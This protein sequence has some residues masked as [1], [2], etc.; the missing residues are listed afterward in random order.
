MAGPHIRWAAGRV[1]PALARYFT[2]VPQSSAAVRA[3]HGCSSGLRFFV[4]LVFSLEGFIGGPPIEGAG[5]GAKSPARALQRPGAAAVGED[6]EVADAVQPGGQD[7]EQEAADELV[8]GDGGGA[9]ARLA[10]L[11]PCP[12][13][14]PEGHALAV[15]GDDAAIRD[16]DPVGVAGE[17]AED[18]LRPAERPLGVD[19]PVPAAGGGEGGVEL[20]GVSEV[21]NGAVEGELALPVGA[22]ELFEEAAAEQVVPYDP[23]GLRETGS[24]GFGMR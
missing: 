3:R 4:D 5:D 6:A 7:V 18:L 17:V 13:S 24:C 12:L 2:D 19:H 11:R 22:G 16:G 21:G 8:D 1:R 23:W 20:T 9:V 10:L 14:V 15:E